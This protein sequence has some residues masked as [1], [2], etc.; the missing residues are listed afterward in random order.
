MALYIKQENKRSQLQ[1][2][3]ATD[4]QERAREKAKE[5][6]LPDGISDSAFIK[7][8]KQTTSLAWVWGVIALIALGLVV[9]LIIATSS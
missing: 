9:W 5:A 2:K 6:E 8:S 1:E 7:G 3:L 4:L